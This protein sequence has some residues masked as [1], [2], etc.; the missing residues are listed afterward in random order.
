MSEVTL[1]P[2]SET[3]A[4]KRKGGAETSTNQDTALWLAHQDT[5]AR[6]LSRVRAWGLPS[7]TQDVPSVLYA[8]ELTTCAGSRS[9]PHISSIVK[10]EAWC[11]HATLK[12]T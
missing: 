7:V 2:S 9:L 5:P 11:A 3:A 6:T 1:F 12:E 10:E 8:S 4:Q